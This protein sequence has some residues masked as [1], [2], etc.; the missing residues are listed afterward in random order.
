M[1]LFR[2]ISSGALRRSALANPKFQF[3]LEIFKSNFPCTVRVKSPEDL[4]IFPFRQQDH[5]PIRLEKKMVFILA[6][7]AAGYAIFKAKDKALKNHKTLADDLASVE[8]ATSM[9]VLVPISL[10]LCFG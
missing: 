10:G 3:G 7:T 4:Y 9:Y 1:H 8:N 5:S 6:E 2:R